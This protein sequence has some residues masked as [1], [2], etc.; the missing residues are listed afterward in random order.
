[1]REKNLII[2]CIVFAILI[3]LTFFK[4]S[5]KPEVPTTEEISDI[6][7]TTINSDSLTKI[8]ECLVHP[9]ALSVILP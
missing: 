7:T 9:R 8:I 1:M 4:K 2:L 5:M 3:S 6:I